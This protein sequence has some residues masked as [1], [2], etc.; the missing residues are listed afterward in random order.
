M[1]NKKLIR[2]LIS[3][4]LVGVGAV[5]I[6]LLSY[7]LFLYFDLFDHSSAKRISYVLG[8]I[9]GFV[10]NKKVTFQSEKKNLREPV[11]FALL[12]L[13]SFIANSTIHD[14]VFAYFNNENIA[15]GVA[16]LVSVALNYLGQKFIVFK[17]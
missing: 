2:E 12:Y 14:W 3:Y 13:F 5:L 10:L 1:A 7:K 16:T 9:W 8:S 15:F 6:D 4:I 17:K 11:L